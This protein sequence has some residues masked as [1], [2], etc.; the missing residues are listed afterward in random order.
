LISRRA[1]SVRE[2]ERGAPG[3]HGAVD[4]LR[5]LEVRVDL[6][7]DAHEFPLALEEGDPVPEVVH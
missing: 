7:F 3:L 4:D 1:P 6:G 5:D 2:Q